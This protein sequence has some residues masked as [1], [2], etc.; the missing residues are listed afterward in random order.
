MRGK[1]TV[2]KLRVMNQGHGGEWMLVCSK[3]LGGGRASRRMRA[4]ERFRC[5]SGRPVKV[6]FLFQELI[7]NSFG[8]FQ[9]LSGKCGN[10]RGIQSSPDGQ[11]LSSH[12]VD[13]F[14]RPSLFSLF[15]EKSLCEEQKN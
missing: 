6:F 11:M 4:F 2:T 9:F 15:S 10:G 13:A 7:E 5:L 12:E 8:L 14:F 3:A 1:V